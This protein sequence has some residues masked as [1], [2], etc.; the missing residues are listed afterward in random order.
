MYAE[1]WQCEKGYVWE[2]EVKVQDKNLMKSWD[3]LMMT[4]NYKKNKY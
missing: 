1:D 4:C 3:E 2:E